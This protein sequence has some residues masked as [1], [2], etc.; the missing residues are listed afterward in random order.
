MVKDIIKSCFHFNNL[1]TLLI[2]VFISYVISNSI[3]TTT[4]IGVINILIIL[5][6]YIIIK[7][8]DKG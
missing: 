5:F 8:S 2:V 1:R 3:I 4:I 7:L 6:I